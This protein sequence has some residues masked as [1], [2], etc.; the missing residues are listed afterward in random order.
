MLFLFFRFLGV[1]YRLFLIVFLCYL[2]L[3]GMIGADGGYILFLLCR[4]EDL[5]DHLLLLLLK[6]WIC[7]LW[8]V[9]ENT[10]FRQVGGEFMVWLLVY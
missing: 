5:L 1:L 9:S 7:G 3:V 2:L 6:L 8:V 10:G 4:W